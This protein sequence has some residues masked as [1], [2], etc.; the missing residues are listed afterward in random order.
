MEKEEFLERFEEIYQKLSEQSDENDDIA[1]ISADPNYDMDYGID[2][3]GNIVIDRESTYFPVE[4]LRSIKYRIGKGNAKP[5]FADVL[6]HTPNIINETYMLLSFEDDV[7]LYIVWD[8][9]SPAPMFR[10]RGIC[11]GY[12]GHMWDD[13]VTR[14][15]IK[16]MR[17]GYCGW[18]DDDSDYIIDRGSLVAYKGN[19]RRV[20]IPEGVTKISEKAFIHSDLISVTMANTVEA[21]ERE[22]FAANFG[23]NEVD[24]KN[25]KTIGDSAFEWTDIHTVVLPETLEYIGKGV[26]EY[27]GIDSENKII[28]H[29]NISVD[30]G[31]FTDYDED[32]NYDEVSDSE[33]MP[34]HYEKDDEIVR[35]IKND[36]MRPFIN[37]YLMKIQN[38]EEDFE[39]VVVNNENYTIVDRIGTWVYLLCG[40]DLDDFL[41]MKE[42]EEEKRLEPI[43]DEAILALAKSRLISRIKEDSLFEE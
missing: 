24:L 42:N 19:E 5:S 22:A 17:H 30:N 15:I 25:V 41:I 36:A 37:F 39:N 4:R 3:M 9:Y 40:N 21:I 26:F 1:C 27:T 43:E 12:E 6:M 13:T 32:A 28:N 16:A 33:I 35:E 2:D 38:Q 20:I 29:S 11:I 10:R 14:A 31:L 18:W 7:R 8:A 34:I 23:L